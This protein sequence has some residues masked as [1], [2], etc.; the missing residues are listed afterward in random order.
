MAAK[1]P[2]LPCPSWHD[3]SA[4]VSIRG[5]SLSG[6]C[7]I[8]SGWNMMNPKE[9]KSMLAV[10]AHPDDES[11]GI[12]GTLTKYAHEGVDVHLICATDGDNGTVEPELLEGYDSVA[13]LREQELRC[14]AEKLGLASV[15]MGG[16]RDSG[17]A[18]SSENMDPRAL[19]AQPVEDFAIKIA[20]RIR[21]VRA[22]VVIT[23]DEIGNYKHPDHIACHRATVLAFKLAGDPVALP[24]TDF[25]AYQ[26]QKLYFNTFP[27]AFMK[28]AVRLAPLFG[29]NPREFGRNKDIDAVELANEGDFPIHLRID[30]KDY[31]EFREQASQ[32][33]VSQLQSGPPSSGFM[34]L[35]FRL[36]SGKELFVRAIPE[37]PRSLREKDMFDGLRFPSQT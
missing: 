37:A 10:M 6:T 25:P 23:H 33:H 27:K 34:S 30:Y 22:Q 12:G 15:Q 3:M 21:Q 4:H 29:V 31:A 28:W 7:G 35:F 5:D 2:F 17:M 16:Y 24:E 9:K 32:C 11:F 8:K 36:M 20:N 14:A 18:G 13:S 26:P 19:A 1:N